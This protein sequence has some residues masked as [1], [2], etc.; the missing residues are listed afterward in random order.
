MQPINKYYD[1]PSRDVGK[2]IEKTDAAKRRLTRT[3]INNTGIFVSFFLVFVV[4]VVF[5][6]EI[7]ITSFEF[8]AQLGLTFFVLFF[9]SYSMYVNCADSGIKAGRSSDVYTTCKKEYDDLKQSVV[10]KKYQARIT[11]FCRYYIDRELRETRTNIL[12]EVGISYEK[13]LSDYCGKD[14]DLLQKDETLSKSMVAAI[15]KAN[16]AKPVTLTPEM[17]FKR[18]RGIGGRHPLG[19]KPETKRTVYYVTKFVRT[20][21]TSVFTGVIVLDVI[22]TPTWATFAACLL[23]IMPVIINGVMGYRMGYINISVD[24]VNYINDQK[25]LLRQLIE[26]AET[27][28][29]KEEAPAATATEQVAEEQAAAAQ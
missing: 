26:Y 11:E 22:K 18:G 28:P 20:L 2:V 12:T 1:R 13:Y 27:N 4:I 24:T 7:K 6:T 16:K 29:L 15:L 25:D 19:V 21:I 3:L 8:W 5:T 17:I 23:K 9:C 14:K 10:D